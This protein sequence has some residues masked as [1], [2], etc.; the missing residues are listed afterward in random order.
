M[1]FFNK[2]KYPG[3]ISVTASET[4]PVSFVNGRLA[5]YAMCVE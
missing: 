4:L 2:F 1:V 3:N 5:E